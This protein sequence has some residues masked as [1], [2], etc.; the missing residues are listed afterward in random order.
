MDEQI[1]ATKLKYVLYARKSTTDET[2]QVRSIPDQIADCKIVA[3]REGLTIID[4]LQET[5]SAKKPNQR[6]IFKQMLIDI[7][8]GK[9]DAILAWNPDRL[10][11][12]MKEGGEIL[13]MID[14]GE[15]VDLK[16]Y[17]H[18]FTKDANGKMLLGM[19]FV[20][21]KQ[22]SDDLSQK[23]TRGVRRSFAEGKSPVPKHGYIRNEHGYY[24]PDG[25]N[26]V[27]IK[28]AWEMRSE[29]ESLEKIAEYMNKNGYKRITKGK[30]KEID[31]DAKILTGLFK[32]PI[33]YGVNIQANQTVDLVELGVN[34]TRATTKEIYNEIQELS[35]RRLKPFNTNRRLTFYPLKAMIR[36]S[37]CDHNM[38]VG[39]STSG[40]TK[41]T[42]YLNY[43]C[44]NK[45]CTR[46]KKSIRAKEIFVFVY[47]F[48]EKGLNLTEADY[49]QYYGHLSQ[50]T[51]IKRQKLKVEIHSREGRLKAIESD[52]TERSLEIGR[53]KMSDE[54]AK[55]NQNKVT[56][57]GLTKQDIEQELRDLRSQL[58]NPDQDKLRL[59]QFLNLS[60]NAAVIVK[61]AN[62]VVKDTICR[63][64]F[65]NF[66]VDET[67]VLSYQLKPPFDEM[68]KTRQ[69]PSS[70]GGGN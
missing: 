37:F 9:Y 22:Y 59:D 54:V 68:L 40:S 26:F 24:E 4:I 57:L 60:K 47:E 65:L 32:D 49:N 16:F 21:S 66:T 17:N 62:P 14:E 48:L 33:Y 67:K 45:A 35:Q 46:K 38:V 25:N 41:K 30:K 39:P 23:V 69:H 19:A 58:T 27:L 53:G 61:S 15:L 51:D 31:M 70:R 3:A 18:T 13:D 44:D 63:K 10:A 7:R 29:G 12:N 36:C 52:I 28:K 1:D 11:R 42:R 34:F 6:P 50:L 5:K 64:I 43:R 8:R 20:L 2:R 56:D 55:V